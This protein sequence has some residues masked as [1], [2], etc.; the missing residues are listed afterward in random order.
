[1]P[2]KR[3]EL[4]WTVRVTVVIK[5]RFQ[6][7]LAY[8]LRTARLSAYETTDSKGATGYQNILKKRISVHKTPSPVIKLTSRFSVHALQHAL[9][10]KIFSVLF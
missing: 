7:Y 4:V 10:Y 6:F 5:L 3:N 8:I 9:E 2:C 1:M